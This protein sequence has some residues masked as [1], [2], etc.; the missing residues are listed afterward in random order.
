MNIF[1]FIEYWMFLIILL[2]FIFLIFSLLLLSFLFKITF[3]DKYFLWFD[4]KLLIL[5]FYFF[6]TCI[7]MGPFSFINRLLHFFNILWSSRFIMGN[8]LLSW[9]FSVFWVFSIIRCWCFYFFRL[10]FAGLYLIVN[11]I[12]LVDG[13][14]EI[15]LVLLIWW[16]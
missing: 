15:G 9:S 10:L 4:S 5:P 14:V 13:R 11:F 1:L 12:V 6:F 8:L 2:F 16:H 3:C 7:L